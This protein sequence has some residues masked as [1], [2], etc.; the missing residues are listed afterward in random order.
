ME[1]CDDVCMH[2]IHPCLKA[3]IFVLD[4]GCKGQGL[5]YGEGHMRLCRAAAKR[6]AQLGACGAQLAS[7]Y[8]GA[9]QQN[10]ELH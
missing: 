10:V 4:F 3:W 6:V 8:V 7:R 1:N 5:D 9:Q 2:P